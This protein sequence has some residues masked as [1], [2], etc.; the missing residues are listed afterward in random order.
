MGI[1]G[2]CWESAD[3][4]A[5][6]ATMHQAGSSQTSDFTMT[7]ER[8]AAASKLKI[9]SSHP[10]RRLDFLI[11]FRASDLGGLFHPR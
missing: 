8:T 4:Q 1:C 6:P 11:A 5:E 3:G 2:K 10:H 9:S 7:P